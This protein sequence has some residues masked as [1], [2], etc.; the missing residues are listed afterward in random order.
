MCFLCFSWHLFKLLKLLF[1]ID[2]VMVIFFSVHSRKR[3]DPDPSCL[4]FS[5]LLSYYVC[6]PTGFLTVICWSNSEMWLIDLFSYLKSWPAWAL[7]T[8]CFLYLKNI[9][10]LHYSFSLAL[11]SHTF[12]WSMFTGFSNSGTHCEE[13]RQNRI[14]CYLEFLLRNK[15]QDLYLLQT[16]WQYWLFRG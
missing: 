5:S 12:L 4:W 14:R 11:Q 6:Y 9:F 13:R 1:S 8:L 15:P 16:V 7:Q 10:Q 2:S 3:H